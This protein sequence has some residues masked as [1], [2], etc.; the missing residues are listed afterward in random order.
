MF[1]NEFSTS[2]A[3]PRKAFMGMHRVQT[4][5]RMSLMFGVLALQIAPQ[6]AALAQ[7]VAPAAAFRI[8]VVDKET[9]WPV[10]M[11]ELRTTHL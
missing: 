11:V 8:E 3:L 2:F 7:A 4:C 5:L 10:P 9:R 1:Q 6:F